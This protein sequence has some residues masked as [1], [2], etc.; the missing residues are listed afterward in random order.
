MDVHFIFAGRVN[1]LREV[2]RGSMNLFRKIG[3]IL[4][5]LGETVRVFHF[6]LY[7]RITLHTRQV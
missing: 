1:Q 4:N 7:T 6:V 5:F 2:L 3:V